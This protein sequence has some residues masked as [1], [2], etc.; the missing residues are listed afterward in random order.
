MSKTYD[1]IVIG[2]GHNG[3]TAATTLAKKNKKVLVLE[4]RSILGGIAAGE[5]FHTGY[6]TTGLLHDTTGVRPG[7]IKALDL[8]KF[9]LKTKKSR[10]TVSILSKDGKCL[11]LSSDV[12]EAHAAIAKFSQKDADAYK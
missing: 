4:K 11:Q 7:V 2:G 6:S 3:L 1:I 9:G 10:P 8:V 12:N 5:E